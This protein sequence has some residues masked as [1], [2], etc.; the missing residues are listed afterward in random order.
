MDYLMLKYVLR[1][2][3]MKLLSLFALQ[4][5]RV[6]KIIG[7]NTKMVLLHQYPAKIIQGELIICLNVNDMKIKLLKDIPGY[8]A[9]GIRQF[10][11]WDFDEVNSHDR[12]KYDWPLL[13]KTGFAEEVKDD[14][15]IEEIRNEI[16]M[17]TKDDNGRVNFLMGINI[18]ELDWFEA[19]RIVK[20]VIEKLNG[21]QKAEVEIIYSNSGN[22]TAMAGCGGIERINILPSC[23]NVQAAKEAISLCES[24]LKVLFGVK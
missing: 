22:F 19:Y 2:H 1:G 7:R 6:L 5:Q 16:G 3:T 24:E 9:G 20:A 4:I 17:W 15:D 12:H 14:I 11:E 23:K 10:P 21:D 8:T 18:K 13:I